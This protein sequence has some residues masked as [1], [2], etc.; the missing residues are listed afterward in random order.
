VI[1]GL[2]HLHK[3]DLIAVDPAEAKLARARRL[4]ADH[5]VAVSDHDV[6][7]A[8]RGLTGGRGADIVVE[9]SG[10]PGQLDVALGAVT[11]GGRVLAVG[12]P[13]QGPELDLS[14]LVLLSGLVLREITLET[15][16]ANVC[17]QD[18]GPALVVLAAG[19]LGPELV[20]SVIALDEL[21]QQGWPG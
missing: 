17:D 8:L 15:R 18:L 10:A 2:R 9:A 7:A 1:A 6:V 20:D 21:P 13:K 4:G 12:L 11:D 19:R 3:A 14:S 5:T 16:V